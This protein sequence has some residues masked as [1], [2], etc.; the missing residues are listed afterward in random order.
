MIC[1]TFCKN[2]GQSVPDGAK[3]CGNCGARVQEEQGKSFCSACGAQ[4]E[5]GAQFC[6]SCGTKVEAGT[7]SSSVTTSRGTGTLLTTW[8]MASLYEGEPKVGIAK[9]TGPLSIYDDRL[10]FKKTM[11]NALGGAFGLIGMGIAQ[12]QANKDPVLIYPLGQVAQL[13]VGKYGGVYNTLVVVMR[14]GTTVSFCPATPAS[15]APQ[16]VIDSLSPYMQKG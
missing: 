4:L 16:N 3:F 8:K 5:A 6:P 12:L 7:N 10:E 9:A 13:R 15:A 2:C 11:G 14:Y 1:R